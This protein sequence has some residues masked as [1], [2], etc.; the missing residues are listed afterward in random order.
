MNEVQDP[1]APPSTGFVPDQVSQHTGCD[2]ESER[3][4]EAQSSGACEGSGREEKQKCRYRQTYLACEHRCE[5][6]GIAML[7]KKL[8]DSVHNKT[9]ARPKNT[10]V[11]EVVSASATRVVQ[12]T[13]GEPQKSTE[14]DSS[15][16]HHG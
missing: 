14:V 16:L 9:S 8:D 6:D 7:H 5:K 1:I 2:R 11:A 13:G 12:H 10:Y 3:G 4:D 15:G